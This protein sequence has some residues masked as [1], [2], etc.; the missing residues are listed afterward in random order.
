MFGYNISLLANFTDKCLF[1]GMVEITRKVNL[2]RT[3]D[4]M[5]HLFDDDF[6]FHPQSW[7]L[8]YQYAEFCNAC[9][10]VTDQRKTKEKQVY[11]VK[12]DEGSQGDGIYLITD[13]KDYNF[14]NRFHVVQEYLA[15]PFLLDDLKFDFRVYVVLKS[16]EPLEIYIYNEGLARFCTVPYEQPTHKNLHEAFMHLTNYS[17]NKRSSGY[18]HTENEDDGSKRTMSSVFKKL[19]HMGYDTARI[20]EEIKKLVVKTIIAITP[21]LKVELRAEI[22]AGKP[23]PSC[24]QVR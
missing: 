23:G 2:C 3:L 8:P 11:I 5:K 9:R 19:R 13:P 15:D 6:D 1:S 21:D 20:W 24:F 4:M 7:F 10:K 14:N 16:L 12:P 18:Q 17:L 22:P